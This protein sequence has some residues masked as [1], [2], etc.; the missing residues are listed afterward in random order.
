[1]T[2]SSTN[3]KDDD[4]ASSAQILSRTPRAY[5]ARTAG[6]PA[7]TSAD[8]ISAAQRA[9]AARI[10]GRR[11]PAFQP[12]RARAVDDRRTETKLISAPRPPTATIAWPLT[13]N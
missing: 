2:F 13:P 8:V 4:D 10:S 12:R 7:G 11:G 5:S 1:M 3:E 9:E 6:V